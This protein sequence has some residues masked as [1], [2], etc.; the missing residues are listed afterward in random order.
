[1]TNPHPTPARQ[2]HATP[3]PP[4]DASR[5]LVDAG[6]YPSTRRRIWRAALARWRPALVVTLVVA[7]VVGVLAMT[8]RAAYLEQGAQGLWA[9]IGTCV[10]MGIPA[11]LDYY[12]R[13]H[14]HPLPPRTDKWR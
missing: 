1:M 7:V 13:A 9:T 12:D 6:R 3:T 4:R 10:V 14:G 11:A 2:H 5:T 8:L